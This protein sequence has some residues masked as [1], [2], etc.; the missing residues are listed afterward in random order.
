MSRRKGVRTAAL[1]SD[2]R[3]ASA[4][5]VHVARVHEMGPV[6]GGRAAVRS[7]VE[8]KKAAQEGEEGQGPTPAARASTVSD[9]DD[10]DDD[11]AKAKK[12]KKAKV[13]PAICGT[14]V[15]GA[16]ARIA[17]PTSAAVGATRAAAGRRARARAGERAGRRGLGSGRRAAPAARRARARRSQ[18]RVLLLAQGHLQARRG[19]RALRLERQPCGHR[20]AMPAAD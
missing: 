18:P 17:A 12:K 4:A 13:T 16:R 11:G 7:K 8:A 20:G 15:G 5:R 14:G 19:V 6:R 9:S 10:S 2:L 3:I 1:A